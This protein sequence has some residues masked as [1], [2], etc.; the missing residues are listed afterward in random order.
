M[1]TT[2]RRVFL[3]SSAAPLWAGRTYGFPANESVTVGIMGMGGR[4]SEL[5]KELGKLPNIHVAYFCDPDAKRVQTALDSFDKAFQRKPETVSDFRRVL[6]DNAVNVL[7]VTTPNHWHAPA[8]IAACNAGKHVYVEKPCSHN[9]YEGELLVAAAD[10]HQRLVQMGNQRRSWPKIREAIE[11]LQGGG[12]GRV[13]FAQSWY[14]N[15]RPSIGRGVERSP[16]AELNFDLWQGPAPRKP[17]HSNYL[18]YNW[19]W[20]WHWGNGELGNN[21]IHMIDLCRWGLGVKHPTGVRSSGGRYR[22]DDDQQ[23]PDTHHVTFDFAEKA[24]IVWE[25]YSCNSYPGGKA[26]ADVV[27]FAEKGSLAIRNGGYTVHDVKGKETRKEI[28][29]GG[30]VEHLTNF[31]ESIRGNAKLNSPVSEGSLSVDLCHLGNIAHRFNRSLNVD[32]NNGKIIGDAEA[33]TLWQRTYEPGWE[34]KA[35]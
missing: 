31:L 11:F 8:A 28:G 20:F 25:G 34:P 17:F 23:T 27:F 29:P 22:F 4:G 19:H 9:P 6:D 26:P 24:S 18:H 33:I 12:L 21:G 5:M 1:S 16:P 3:A 13:Y 32:R 7:F 35:T 30:N 2:T 10:K 14:T 15:N